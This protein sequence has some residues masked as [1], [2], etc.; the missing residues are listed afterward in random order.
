MATRFTA[1]DIVPS[2]FSFVG[3]SDPASYDRANGAGKLNELPVNQSEVR[4]RAASD[5]ENTSVEALVVGALAW[6][7]A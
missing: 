1:S 2:M 3:G 7:S 4:T 6:L 5:V